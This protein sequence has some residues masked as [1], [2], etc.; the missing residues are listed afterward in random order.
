[1]APAIGFSPVGIAS[2]NTCGL[3]G[4]IV[5]TKVRKT[6]SVAVRASSAQ[7][8]WALDFTS[9]SNSAYC[10]AGLLPAGGPLTRS[11]WGTR[12]STA[13]FSCGCF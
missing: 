13:A 1:M 9:A 11:R 10:N 3:F 12:A 2:Y 6:A 7:E 8:I 5:D 4:D